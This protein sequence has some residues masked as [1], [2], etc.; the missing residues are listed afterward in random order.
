MKFVR[1]FESVKESRVIFKKVREDLRIN[2]Y[3][4]VEK[5]INLVMNEKFWI[6]VEV[7]GE[8]CM[9]FFLI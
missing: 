9:Y 6:N 1:R 4:G 8:L 7:F 2:F 3:V 5:V